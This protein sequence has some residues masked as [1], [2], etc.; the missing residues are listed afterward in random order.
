M[1]TRPTASH[2][3]DAASA[4]AQRRDARDSLLVLATLRLEDGSGRAET[5]RVRNVSSG[6]LM[7]QASAAFGIGARLTVELEGIGPVGGSVAWAEVG[8][9]GIA[10]DHPVDK[11]RAR[12]PKAERGGSAEEQLFRPLASGHKRPPI[13]PR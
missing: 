7:A 13:K 4:E 11:A 12:K 6:G 2:A 3:Q 1:D 5:V 10:F 8:R 9:I